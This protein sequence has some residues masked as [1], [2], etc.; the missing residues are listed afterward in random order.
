MMPP[1]AYWG[2]AE[3]IDYYRGDL[4]TSVRNDVRPLVASDALFG[5][6]RQ[7]FPYVEY[8]SGLVFGPAPGGR[9]LATTARAT[10]FLTR[11]MSRVDPLYGKHA[12]LLLEMW[13]H[14]LVHTYKP[15]MLKSGSGR[16][17]GWL[18]YRG[19][20]KEA[21]GP[22]GQILGVAGTI[23][24]LTLRVDP[25]PAGNLD[26]LPVEIGSLVDDLEA[27]LQ[28][29]AADLD[30]ERLAGGGPLLGKMRAAAEFLEQPIE[31]T[32]LPYI[33]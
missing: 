13:R 20:R 11:F 2:Y 31:D 5:V 1:F 10:D 28:L 4:T 22:N 26:H 24:H 32:R 17:L 7:F 9:N 14:G 27:V 21:T 33:W 23:S 19:P 12:R 18:S 25:N 8:L 15:K 30:G 29:I 6:P 3:W 16:L